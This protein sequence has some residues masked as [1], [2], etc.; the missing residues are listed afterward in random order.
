MQYKNL[1]NLGA[2]RNLTGREQKCPWCQTVVPLTMM[3]SSDDIA[4]CLQCAHKKWAGTPDHHKWWAAARSARR[5]QANLHTPQEANLVCALSDATELSL[6]VGGCWIVLRD[7]QLGESERITAGMAWS[8]AN[9]LREIA[10]VLEQA[11]CLA[12]GMPDLAPKDKWTWAHNI[13]C[14]CGQCEAFR[15][16]LY[17][18]AP[19]SQ[20]ETID[21]NA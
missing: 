11:A 7:P 19:S 1:C 4:M 17:S 9:R 8:Y 10:S 2:S 6:V 3:V 12:N 5:K 21:E 20:S 16:R 15:V 13:D 18:K 14:P